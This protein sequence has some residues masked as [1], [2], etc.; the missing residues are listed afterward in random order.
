LYRGPYANDDECR[1]CGE[2]RFEEDTDAFKHAQELLSGNATNE[3][4]SIIEKKKKYKAR[5]VYRYSPLIPR[6]KMLIAHPIMSILLK[7]ADEHMVNEDPNIADD[8][9]QAPA[10]HKFAQHFPLFNVDRSTGICDYRIA[11]GIGADRASMS[12]DKQRN[13][14]AVLPILACIM[15]WPIWFRSK[16]KHL[17]T[18]GLPPLASHNPSIFFGKNNPFH[19][20]V[21]FTD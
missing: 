5:Y 4:V 2:C 18:V 14:Y 15:N 8:I 13:D 1:K 17:L 9:H 12:K 19:A 21:T 10:Y 16:E 7:Y 20:S 3:H 6:L 11:L